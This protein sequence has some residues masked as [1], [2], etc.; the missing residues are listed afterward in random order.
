MHDGTDFINVE[1]SGYSFGE[2]GTD[3]SIGE[4]IERADRR[5]Q[6]LDIRPLEYCPESLQAERQWPTVTIQFEDRGSRSRGEISMAIEKMKEVVA[7][8]REEGVPFFFD[9]RIFLA[10]RWNLQMS[11]EQRSNWREVLP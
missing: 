4:A 9:L 6:E 1:T 11:P 10:P 5:A 3:P 2:P 7:V 8:Y